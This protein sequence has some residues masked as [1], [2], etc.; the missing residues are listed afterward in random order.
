MTYQRRLLGSMLL[1]LAACSSAN[2]KLIGK[3]KSVQSAAGAAGA[4]EPA[5]APV[6]VAGANL[7]FDCKVSDPTHSL[8]SSDLE[9]ASVDSNHLPVATLMEYMSVEKIAPGSSTPTPVA[10]KTS[11]TPS[12]PI[13]VVPALATSEFAQGGQLVVRSKVNGVDQ[14]ILVDLLTLKT[15][16]VAASQ[17][18]PSTS[19]NAGTTSP[20]STPASVLVGSLYGQWAGLCGFDVGTTSCGLLQSGKATGNGTCNDGFVFDDVASRYQGSSDDGAMDTRHMGVCFRPEGGSALDADMRAKPSDFA[21]V[22]GWYGIC[23]YT[24]TWTQPPLSAGYNTESATCDGGV[25]YPMNT[26][27]TCPAGFL[28]THIAG[29]RGGDDT[30]WVGTCVAQATGSRAEQAPSGVIEGFCAY[31]GSPVPIGSTPP[32]TSCSAKQSGNAQTRGACSNGSL[33]N[34]FQARYNGLNDTWSGVC[35]KP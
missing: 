27:K 16:V 13:L 3:N 34:S 31:S 29:K 25:K 11:G 8:S 33:F 17:Y 20:A 4:M 35:V 6:I 7:T 28:F 19:S 30:K 1:S 18:V 5:S 10:F 21:V 14:V 24:V 12:S 22:N 23:Y 15:Q 2:L 32:A 9:C 26:D